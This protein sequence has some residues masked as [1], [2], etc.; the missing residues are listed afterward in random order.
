MQLFSIFYWNKLALVMTYSQWRLLHRG[1]FGKDL[2]TGWNN[3]I[4]F[5]LSY[6]FCFI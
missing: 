1:V 5:D 6:T 2:N 4:Q 3:W